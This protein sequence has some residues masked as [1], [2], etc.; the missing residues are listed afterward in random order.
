MIFVYLVFYYLFLFFYG[1]N[2][3][4]IGDIEIKLLEG[5]SFISFITHLLFNIFGQSDITLR[6]PS[7][8]FSIMSLVLYYYVA[9]KVLKNKKDVYM[10]VILFTLLPGFIISTIL[11]NKSIYLI[12]LTLYFVYLFF[13]RRFLS[14]II[15]SFFVFLDYS[16]VALYFGL[17]FYAIYKK[18]NLLIIYSLI[19]FMLNAN[20]FDYSIG[21]VPRGEFVN[22]FVVYS[23]IFSPFLFIYF[24]YSLYKYL[25]K[26]QK[27]VLW[28]ISFLAFFISIVLSF[29]QRIRIDDF[30]P[31]VVISSIFMIKTFFESYR[32]RLNIFRKPYKFLFLFMISSILLFDFIIFNNKILYNFYDKPNKHLM[33]KFHNTKEIVSI[34]RD[35]NIDKVFCENKVFCEKLYFYGVTKGNKFFISDYELEMSEKVSVLSSNRELK[36]IYVSKVNT[37][38]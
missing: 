34:L 4:S 38:K 9:I 21:G 33:Y 22:L 37:S 35:K 8:I 31:Y 17:F 11:V 1:A 15:L 13:Y 18:Q 23:A 32:V 6:L 36:T 25:I 5:S 14:Y 26:N 16:F 28:F 12:F 3:L 27:N 10:A 19:L 2:F 7:F 20:Y 30:A 29:R 24:I